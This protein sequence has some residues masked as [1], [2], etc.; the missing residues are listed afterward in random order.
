MNRPYLNPVEQT[1]EHI[2]T[3][4]GYDRRAVIASGDSSNGKSGTLCFRDT[5][6]VVSDEYP[7]VRTREKR[8]TVSISGGTLGSAICSVDNKLVYLKKT[9]ATSP[10]AQKIV[11]NGVGYD[12]GLSP[13]GW[14]KLVKMGAYIIVL[15]ARYKQSGGLQKF[16]TWYPNEA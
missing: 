14:Y 13:L 12:I 8:G 11:I 9:P 4:G 3:F 15:E 10:T 1:R 16:D 2:R 5:E 6:G 7:T